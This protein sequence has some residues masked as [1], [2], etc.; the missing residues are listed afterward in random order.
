MYCILWFGLPSWHI[1][2]WCTTF[3]HV[4]SVYVY[5]YLIHFKS[6]LVVLTWSCSTLSIAFC[7]FITIKYTK[8]LAYN[9]LSINYLCYEL[10]EPTWNRL[11]ESIPKFL[12]MFLWRVHNEMTSGLSIKY[13]FFLDFGLSS[14]RALYANFVTS[15]IY[16]HINVRIGFR[17]H[18]CGV[19][20]SV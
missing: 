13:V 11:R 17:G 8:S 3:V 2:E 18:M 12:I 20:D 7:L 9:Y 14:L 4:R 15:S 10:R 5:K 19:P 1:V 6:Y 16:L